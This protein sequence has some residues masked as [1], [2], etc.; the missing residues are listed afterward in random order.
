MAQNWK[1]TSYASSN[2]A[3]SDLTDFE[4]NFAVLRSN[5]SGT[6]APS[7][8]ILEA[9]LFWFDTTD[10]VMKIRNAAN[11]GWQ[12]LMYGDV[13][14]KIWVYLNSAPDGW[15]QDS[16]PTDRVVAVK[17]GAT[18]VTGGAGAGS[19]TMSGMTS[20]PNTHNHQWTQFTNPYGYSWDDAGNLIAMTNQAHSAG[21]IVSSK[22]D[23]YRLSESL[24]A[25]NE[26][27][28]HSA[29][30]YATTFRP[31]S[32]VGILVYPNI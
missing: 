8:G 18:Y 24:W 19:W 9:G 4:T 7:A 12:G 31:A 3:V 10:K 17:G 6:S 13:D 27:H 20:N 5:F 29:V 21:M 23:P 16:S 14:T 22:G 15:V 25:K 11:N 30:T 26:T 32:A 1:D 2:V 28:S